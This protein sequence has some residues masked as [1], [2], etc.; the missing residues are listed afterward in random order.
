ML[1]FSKLQGG[2]LN[3]MKKEYP[4]LPVGKV[5]SVVGLRREKYRKI[6]WH[7]AELYVKT[8]LPLDEY[9]SLINGIVH[10]CITDSGE[11]LYDMVDF[12]T[13]LNI[14]VAYALVE[15]PNNI[16]DLYYTIYESD[17]YQTIC[18]NVNKGQVESVLSFV[19][20]YFGAGV[21]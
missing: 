2:V 8:F 14:V 16:D 12:A 3:T 11:P 18:A 1:L 4:I 5:R 6:V 13:R 21:G 17:L 7:S 19:N 20:R 15:L 9:R 10:Y